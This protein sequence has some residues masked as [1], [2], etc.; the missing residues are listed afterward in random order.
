M[1]IYEGTSLEEQRPDSQLLKRFININ[2]KA[3]F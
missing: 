2:G 1:L 3:V